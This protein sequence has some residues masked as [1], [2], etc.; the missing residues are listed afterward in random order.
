MCQAP[1]DA[2]RDEKRGEEGWGKGETTRERRRESWLGPSGVIDRNVVCSGPDR[3]AKIRS[4]C[5]QFTP[6]SR[7]LLFL[8][9]LMFRF[10][11]WKIH[12]SLLSPPDGK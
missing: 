12:F 9:V 3:D 5:A 6:S 2:K 4:Y 11:C 1:L 7:F 8:S 10:A